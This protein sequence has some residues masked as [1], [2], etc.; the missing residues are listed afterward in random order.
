MTAAKT[1]KPPQSRLA[2][3]LDGKPLDDESARV[4]W[5]EFSGYMDTR[6]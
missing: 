5:V 6:R 1:K 2:V 3:L 4:L